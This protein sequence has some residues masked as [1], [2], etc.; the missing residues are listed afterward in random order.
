MKKLLIIL[1]SLITLYACSKANKSMV[2]YTS[3]AGILIELHSGNNGDFKEE[4]TQVISNNTEFEQVWKQAYA[5][6]MIKDEMPEVDFEKNVVLLVAMG[7]K[8]SGGHTIKITH[9]TEVNNNSIANVIATSPGK[10]CMTTE[11]ITYPFQIVQIEKTNKPIEFK[12]EKKVIDC[13]SK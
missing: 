5:N 11:S 12:V 1:T 2:K 8:T 6:F 13:E 3:K 7:E 10:G 4:T 9:L